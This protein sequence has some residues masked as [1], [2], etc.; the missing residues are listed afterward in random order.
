MRLRL[1]SAL[2]TLVFVG[3]AKLAIGGYGHRGAVW[4]DH[5]RVQ[6]H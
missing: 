6:E 2:V 3:E 5:G 1:I 4:N